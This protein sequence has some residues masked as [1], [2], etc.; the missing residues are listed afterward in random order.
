[1]HTIVKATVYVSVCADAEFDKK[2]T[3]RR[4]RLSDTQKRLTEARKKVSDLQRKHAKPETQKNARDRVESIRNSI[5]RQKKTIADANK[6]AV[7]KK[8]KSKKSK[9][10]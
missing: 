7:A 8:S 9:E 1:M 2:Q 3:E 6:K 4:K 10:E 5:Q